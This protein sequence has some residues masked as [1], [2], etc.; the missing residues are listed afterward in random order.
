MRWLRSWVKGGTDELG[1]DDW[2]RRVTKAV[3]ETAHYGPRGAVAFPAEVEV[4]VVAPPQSAELAREFL[5]RPGFDREVGAEL[6]NRWDCEP[7]ALPLRAYRVEEGEVW[8]VR[9]A[10]AAAEARWTLAVAGGDR[11]GEVLELPAGRSEVRFGRGPWH[12]ADRQVRNDLVVAGDAAF[13][14]RRAGR[15]CAAGHLLEVEALDQGDHL[16]VAR[17]GG[18][19]V[20]PARAA[21]GRAMLQEGDAIELSG[22]D[23]LKI[24]LVLER[25]RGSE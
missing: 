17:A 21:S 13:V 24:R 18:E 6:A 1:W 8:E 14:S 15:L 4:R 12:G 2:I 10:I 5:R 22:G 3:G 7:S 11:D 19:Y 9:A 20:R 16:A 25:R 23:E